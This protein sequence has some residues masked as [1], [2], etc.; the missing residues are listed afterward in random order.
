M[1]KVHTVLEYLE[2]QV[3]NRDIEL[4]Y[5]DP[6]ELLVATILSAQCTDQRVNQVTTSLFKKY[7]SA[8][9]Y[10]QADLS[11]IEE[12]IR[13]TGFFR[14]KAKSIKGCCQH[15]VEKHQGRVPESME[16]LTALPGVGRKTA[17]V[18][19][20]TCFGKPAIV[21]DTHV[22]RVANRLGLSRSDAPDKIEQDL[23]KILPKTRWTASSHQL[24]LHG[25]YI[26]KAKSPLCGQC[27]IYKVCVW[28]DKEKYRLPLKGS[29]GPTSTSVHHKRKG[30]AAARV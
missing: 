7:K 10:A 13:P 25:R 2:K 3:G 20:G 12:E 24:L 6:L 17:N 14:A 4:D 11:A 18:I 19:L 1:N 28:N 16:A 21:V 26:C 30:R 8:E 5:S 23:A 22:K 29:G 27:V 9:E 15:L